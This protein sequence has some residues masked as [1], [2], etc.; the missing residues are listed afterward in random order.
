MRI[1]GEVYQPSCRAY[2]SRL[3]EP[4][5]GN[6]WEVRRVRECGRIRWWSDSVFIGK[7]L[8]GEVIALEPQQDGL[9][10]LWFFDY[11][12]GVLDERKRKVRKLPMPTAADAPGTEDGAPERRA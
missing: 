7:A 2:P 11:P 3:A 12:I 6:G 4:K 1:P 9:W 8:S 10:T 5:Y